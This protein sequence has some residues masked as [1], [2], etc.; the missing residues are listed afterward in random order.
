MNKIKKWLIHTLWFKL[1]QEPTV[2]CEVTH[3]L[4]WQSK[5]INWSNTLVLFLYTSCS[6]LIYREQKQNKKNNTFKL[7]C[8]SAKANNSAS[9]DEIQ[10]HIHIFFLDHSSAAIL[11][12]DY[13]IITSPSKTTMEKKRCMSSEKVWIYVVITAD[14]IWLHCMSNNRINTHVNKYTMIITIMEPTA[15]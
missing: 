2:Q 3:A 6:S 4:W 11:P 12:L 15:N 7:Y 8:N 5:C 1:I 9:F 14:R 10:E 13:I